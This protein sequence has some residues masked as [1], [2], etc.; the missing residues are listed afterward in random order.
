[1]MHENQDQNYR[2]RRTRSS[3]WKSASESILHCL[4]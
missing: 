3:Q 2:S 4:F 1:M